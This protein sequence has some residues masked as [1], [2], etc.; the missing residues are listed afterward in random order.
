MIPT[1]SMIRFDPGS[2]VRVQ[3]RFTTGQGVKRRPAVILSDA[4]YHASRADAIV[5]ALSSQVTVTY[6]GDC[7]L[8]DWNRAGLP[9][10]TKAKGVLQT[11]DRA[12]IDHQYGS[13]TD[14]DLR[15]VRQSVRQILGV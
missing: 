9:L 4:P 11:V 15:R 3:I 12:S 1:P 6:Y 8:V 2:V 10:P 13:L 7:D 5:I 14:A